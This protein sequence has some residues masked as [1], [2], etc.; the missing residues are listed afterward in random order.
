MKRI[1]ASIRFTR[2]S[3]F[4]FSL[5]LCLY[6]C[7]ASTANERQDSLVAKILSGN[8]QQSKHSIVMAMRSGRAIAMPKPKTDSELLDDITPP[9]L[10]SSW[11]S[12]RKPPRFEMPQA[13]KWHYFGFEVTPDFAAA[14]RAFLSGDGET[15]IRYFDHVIQEQKKDT[16]RQWRASYELVMTHIMMGRP[17]LAEAELKN[18]EEKES[19]FMDSNMATLGLRAE[20]RFWSGDL[21]GALSDTATVIRFLGSWQFQ[22]EFDYMP[23]LEE[24]RK[25]ALNS[26]ARLRAYMVRGACLIAKGRYQD[27]LPWLELAVRAAEDIVSIASNPSYASYIATYPEIF[28]GTGMCL[29][30]LG[31]ALT[32]LEPDSKR[33]KVVFEWASEYFN[34]IGYAAGNV[35][36]EALKAHVLLNTDHPD[37]A[38]AAARKGLAMAEKLELLDFIWR[39]ETVNG[40]G[41]IKL[42]QWNE[43][44]K[45]L[46]HAQSVVDLISGTMA[47]DE[48]KV[49]FGAG[50]EKITK[51]LVE[52]DVK[53]K[54][55]ETLFQDMERGRACAF[56]S[57]LAQRDV[58]VGRQPEL[59]AKI[60]AMDKDILKERR[61][62]NAFSTTGKS[63]TNLE[64]ELLMKRAA[65]VSLL[66]ERDPELADAFS[67]SVADL[68]SV[69]KKLLPGEVMAY[70]L[71]ATGSEPIRLLL[72]SRDRVVLKALPLTAE[73]LRTHLE[74]FYKA[75]IL[76]AKIDEERSVTITGRKTAAQ[77]EKSLERAVL[78]ELVREL[79]PDQWGAATAAYVVPSGDMHF[80]PWGALD[81]RFPV[82][83]LPTGGWIVRS[84]HAGKESMKASV[85][86]DPDFGGQLPQLAGARTEAIAVAKEYGVKPLIGPEASEPALRQSVGKGVDVLHLA[87]HALYD[88]YLPLQSALLLTD[89]KKAVPLTAER[90]FEKPLLSR[91][92]IL[93]AC[94]TGMGQVVAGD[95]ILGLVRSFYLGGTSAVLSSLWPVEDAATQLFMETFHTRSKGGDFGG[96]WL[97]A[98]DTLRNRGYSPS[99]YGAF[100]LGGSLGVKH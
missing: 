44:E 8:E 91:L 72:I 92:V 83:V 81:V 13:K 43:A 7:A 86:G 1:S 79:A 75:R 31:T 69:R 89:G 84:Y 23:R 61:K 4:I 100:I 41:L 33:A 45:A 70:V 90:I 60:R 12:Y 55:Y 67:V 11:S 98:R 20:V 62:K 85:V 74:A 73:R 30:G 48:A 39:L 35:T 21:D 27:A 68:G 36:I 97:A 76:Q 22:T 77:K 96:A 3:V 56:V 42:G 38:V 5:I 49:R 37:L 40:E 87:T 99:A 14:N 15:A 63:R 78:D 19:K 18:T 47:T 9:D 80:I 52:I 46:R 66:R 57:M 50:K 53:K 93:S 51:Y 17:D 25:I 94:E 71:P 26:S 6:G 54:D 34:T 58:A 82:V 95:D 2:S 64:H 65:L 32:A 59:I 10:R 16:A 28:Y 29:A 88:P 24:F